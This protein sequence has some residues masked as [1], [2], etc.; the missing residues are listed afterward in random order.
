MANDP[1][2]LGIDI[3]DRST[4]LIDPEKLSG[5]QMDRFTGVKRWPSG[6]RT[7]AKRRK[8][9]GNCNSSGEFHSRISPVITGSHARSFY[10]DPRDKIP[11]DLRDQDGFVGAEHCCDRCQLMTGTLEGLRSLVSPAGYQHFTCDQLRKEADASGCP[12]CE[13]AMRN[14]VIRIRSISEEDNAA[15]GHPFRRSPRLRG[16]KASIPLDP[17]RNSNGNTLHHHELGVLAF[18]ESPVAPYVVGR[19]PDKKLTPDLVQQLCKWFGDCQ[20]G[21]YGHESCPRRCSPKLPTRVVDIGDID[22][23]PFRLRTNQ[24]ETRGQYV[25]LSYCW[26]GDQP[27]KTTK[28]NLDSYAQEIDPEILPK[29]LSD[30]IKVC[31]ILAIRYIWID[32]LCIVQDDQQDKAREIGQMGK[33]YKNATLTIMAASAKSVYTGFLDDAKIDAPEA[34]LPW[35][36]DQ[37]SFGSI[38]VRTDFS[39]RAY[40]LDEEPIFKRA[41]TL[42]EML[43]SS[44]IIMFDSYQATLKCGRNDFWPAMPTYLRPQTRLG[45]ASS[46]SLSN[47]LHEFHLERLAKEYLEKP[48]ILK[49]QN[50]EG[51]DLDTCEF[52]NQCRMWAAVMTEYSRRD[53]AVL[54]DRFPALAGITEELQKIWGGEFVAGF[55]KDSL[56]QHLGWVGGVVM[57]EQYAGNQWERRLEGP[58]WS[59]MSHPSSV[60]IDPV[61]ITDVEVLGYEVELAFPGQPF[62]PVKWGSLALAARTMP[63]SALRTRLQFRENDDPIWKRVSSIMPAAMDGIALD[64]PARGVPEG[65]LKALA[66]GLTF[67]VTKEYCVTFLVLRRLECDTYE[68]IGQA[69]LHTGS[70]DDAKAIM[71]QAKMEVVVIE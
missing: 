30:A 61:V 56:V 36:L 39:G 41:W 53:L 22:G 28:A 51:F 65:E 38:F 27:Y 58:S 16:L 67:D 40:F 64:F 1:S 46:R 42:Q 10:H 6:G 37:D 52:S 35:H 18:Q 43:L 60:S 45:S 8:P 68:R 55:W 31:R 48:S 54:D 59:W 34:K 11:S 66:L 44:R 70:N 50:V 71:S 47:T 25:A 21:H 7:G 63:L 29:T 69:V 57:N 9:E 23:T 19:R 32:A 5:E 13:L 12:F 4:W 14:G 15:D 49:E 62:G 26:G 17:L 33:I 3:N 24:T 20:D 2:C